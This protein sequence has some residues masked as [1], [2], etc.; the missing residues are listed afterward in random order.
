MGLDWQVV[1]DRWLL[2]LKEFHWQEL[3]KLSA[4]KIIAPVL[5]GYLIQAVVLGVI[6]YAL[7]LALLN[8]RKKNEDKNRVDIP[9]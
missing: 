7:T 4:L 2:F 3:L 1:R 9:G 8:R 6:T 5:V